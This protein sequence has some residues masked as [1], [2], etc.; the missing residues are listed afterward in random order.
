MNN[1]LAT[2]GTPVLLHA[3]PEPDREAAALAFLRGI[4]GTRIRHTDTTLLAHLQGVYAKLKAW[5][6]RDDLCFAG[7]FHSVYGTEHFRRQT[8]PIAARPRV[9]KVIGSDAEAL[10]FQFCTLDTRAFLADVEAFLGARIADAPIDP[11]KSDLLHLFVANWL[12]QFPRMRA[13]QR[14]SHIGFL[15]HARPLLLPAA[16]EEVEAT[17]GFNLPLTPRDSERELEALD[18]GTGTLRILDDFVPLHLRHQLSA[19]MGRNIWRYGWKAAD[20][21]TSHFFW[22]SHFAGDSD[23]HGNTDCEHE[24]HNRPLVSP[25]LEL[26]HLIRDQLAP[27]HVPVRVYANGQT[28]G[29]DGHIHSD[30]DQPGHF[31]SLYYAHP[32]WDPNWGGETLFYN[33]GKSDV[34]AAAYPR[35]GRLVHFSGNI[36]HAARS[37][38]RDCPALRSVIVIKTYCPAA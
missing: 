6:C 17:F 24:L 23:D 34:V 31:T 5:G 38:S 10:A 26:W 7:L 28:Y 4:P 11:E 33:A 21:Q 20:T 8:I 2:L 12:E 36:F 35:P 25:V 19:L 3:A 22:H 29:G 13:S 1:A 27:G 18:R 14:S 9:T 37:P 15:R 32:E 16:A 30:A